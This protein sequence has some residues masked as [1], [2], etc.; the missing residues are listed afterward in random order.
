M[1]TF[2]ALEFDKE[3]K[4]KLGSIQYK[5]KKNSITG[6][7]VYVDNFHLT[8][9]FLGTTNPQNVDKI[10]ATLGDIAK[11]FSSMSFFLDKLGFFPGKDKLRVVWV[12]IDGDVEILEK[13][14]QDIEEL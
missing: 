2:I 9:K 11:S 14:R 1:R 4:N 13:L 10:K 3:L 5:L 7:W 6:R 8:L 12:G